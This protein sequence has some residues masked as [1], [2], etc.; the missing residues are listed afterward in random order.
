MP[1]T[2]ATGIARTTTDATSSTG[3]G[4]HENTGAE[5]SRDQREP[6]GAQGAN[7]MLSGHSTGANMTSDQ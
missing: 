2:G 1:G 7:A 3:A 6:G 5:G 4:L